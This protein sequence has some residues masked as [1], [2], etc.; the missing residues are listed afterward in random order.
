SE[1]SAIFQVFQPANIDQ[2]RRLILTASGG[3][4]RGWSE[5]AMAAATLEQAVAHPTWDMGAKI[6]VDCATMM[7][8][9]LEMIE[10]S[11]L[12]TMP[13]DRIEVIIHPQSV[14]HSL[15]EYA[16]GSTLAQLGPPDMRAPIACAWAWPARIAWPAE[17]LDLA[18]I[19]QLTFEAPDDTRF[20]AL[21]IARQALRAGAG[22]SAAMNAANEVAVAA[23]LDRQIGFL[24]IAGTVSR[25]LDE[26]N[27]TGG[28]AAG[29]DEEALDWA[30]AIDASGRRT[31]AQVLS[32][33]KR[34]G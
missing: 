3:P 16:D 20:P 25:T 14:V 13:A 23:F 24:D 7:N 11:Y 27:D 10:A 26:M 32:R 34:K 33:L 1:H 5:A 18:A 30:L 12:F 15:V 8:K 28:L 4:F 29:S 31:A 17:R 6:S 19:G 9:G 2:V 21:A 22:A